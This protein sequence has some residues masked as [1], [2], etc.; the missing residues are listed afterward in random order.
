MHVW[1]SQIPFSPALECFQGIW[2]SPLTTKERALTI[3]EDLKK[4]LKI[5]SSFSTSTSK[6][7]GGFGDFYV[8]LLGR[9][10]VRVTF[11][12]GL[13]HAPCSLLSPAPVHSLT[14]ISRSPPDCPCGPLQIPDTFL[15]QGLC[16]CCSLCQESLSWA[17]TWFASS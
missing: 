10:K 8:S 11:L 14:A 4:K 2:G 1:P 7:S 15:S 5:L 17:S 13:E 12:L 9:L 6:S 16:T 3:H